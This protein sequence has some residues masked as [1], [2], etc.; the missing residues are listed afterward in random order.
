MAAPDIGASVKHVV[1]CRLWIYL[2]AGRNIKAIAQL[3]LSFPEIFHRRI[4]RYYQFHDQLSVTL[5]VVLLI[6]HYLYNIILSYW[7][8][9]LVQD[10]ILLL[11]HIAYVIHI[12]IGVDVHTNKYSNINLRYSTTI[13]PWIDYIYSISYDSYTRNLYWVMLLLTRYNC[14]V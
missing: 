8:N 3:W 13:L 6:F 9:I 7:V 14:T 10:G 4:L 2:S 11:S 12:E 1:M 5:Q